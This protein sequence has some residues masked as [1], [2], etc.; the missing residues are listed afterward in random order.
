VSS[1]GLNPG[2]GR[3]MRIENYTLTAVDLNKR[4]LIYRMILDTLRVDHSYISWNGRISKFILHLTLLGFEN[5]LEFTNKEL[6][7]PKL[8]KYG[9]ID[10][11]YP[12][13]M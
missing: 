9:V 13:C 3:F 6:H 12:V 7:R 8:L 4:A 1:V 2:S 11:Q 5:G 10:F